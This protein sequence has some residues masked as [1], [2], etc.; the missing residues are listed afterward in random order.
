MSG[1]II[2]RNST[3][4]C[5]SNDWKLTLFNFCPFAVQIETALFLEKLILTY[6]DSIDTKTL[7]LLK[8]YHEIAIFDLDS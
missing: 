4:G 1:D 8:E 2:D 7:R 3:F 5:A 6:F